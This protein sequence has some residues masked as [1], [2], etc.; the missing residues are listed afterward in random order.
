MVSASRVAHGHKSM[1]P[2]TWIRKALGSAPH[3]FN[4]AFQ[5]AWWNTKY[6]LPGEYNANNAANSAIVSACINWLWRSISGAEL[7]VYMGDSDTEVSNPRE[8]LAPL[9]E[10]N[11]RHT[12]RNFLWQH[13]RD[14]IHAGEVIINRLDRNSVQVLPWEGVIQ[15]LP[16]MDGTRVK[17]RAQTLS[18][19]QEI[20]EREIVKIIWQPHPDHAY[21]GVSPL[22]SCN[23][24]LLLD[25]YAREATAGRL[26]SPVVGLLFQPK[27]VD[28]AILPESDL[29]ELK[30][31]MTKLTGTGVGDT[32]VGEARYD[33]KELEGVA[34]K[35][36]YSLI[37]SLVEARVCAQVGV[38][39]AVAQMGAG[40]QQTRVG[41]TMKEEVRL[42]Y[43]NG[44][45]PM[46]KII[47]EGWSK[48]LLPALGRPGYRIE[49]DFG[50]FDHMTEQEVLVKARRYLDT[51]MVEGLTEQ[52]R[53]ILIDKLMELP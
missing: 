47:G 26:Q 4:R 22:R 38:P 17:Y 48:L 29:N 44:A 13:C 51:L 50:A 7:K 49:F 5:Y 45:I 8:V 46:A 27:E 30:S 11:S 41:A 37:Y 40:L 28:G 23:A 25:K 52:E 20:P 19:T 36:D 35:F 31:E 21:L 39:P 53:R 10:P 14:L 43:Q 18:G 2:L 9:L 6:H 33:I 15:Q 1:N 16:T 24:E 3:P 32:F 42:A 34:H 12:Y